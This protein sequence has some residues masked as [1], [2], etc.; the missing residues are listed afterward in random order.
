MVVVLLVLLVSRLEAVEFVVGFVEG[1]VGRTAF[2]RRE[3]T[4]RGHC[5]VS[6][7]GLVSARLRPG[8]RAQGP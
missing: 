2:C 1:H 5:A 3:R 4:N 8:G 6:G 7:V